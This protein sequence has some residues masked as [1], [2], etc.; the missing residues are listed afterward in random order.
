VQEVRSGSTVKAKYQYAADG[1]KLKV[2]DSGN[3]NSY[4][5]L[6]SV[7]LVKNTNT[8]TPEVAFAEGIIRGSNILF[9]EK[10]HLAIYES[11][12]S[13]SD[14]KEMSINLNFRLID[15]SF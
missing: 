7:T 15:I 2:Q 5:Y 1:T 11:M 13:A 10:D 8:I 9:F 12:S 4:D 6:G 14:L 3:T